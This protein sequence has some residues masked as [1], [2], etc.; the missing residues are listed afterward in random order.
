MPPKV[1]ITREAISSA[2]VELVRAQGADALNARSLT[3]SLHCSTQPIFFNFSSMGE[4]RREVENAAFA[5]YRRYTE[6]E[7]ASGH[8]PPYK[9]SG[10]AYI[11]FA[12]EER[13][14]FRLL[15]M[16]DRR[17]LDKTEDSEQYA[18]VADLVQ[19]GTG[20][21]SQQADLFHLEMWTFVHG[22]ATMLATG[23]LELDLE[24][25]SQMMTD[26]FQGLRAKHKA[27]ENPNES[28]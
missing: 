7:I 2:A 20:L 9:A 23:Y 15:Y 28:H 18:W 14:L 3:Q 12:K 27:K 25:I 10:M 19:S 13:E 22:I 24:L 1:K 26:V 4:L 8:Y 5:L 11:R 21:S 6:Q 16:R 17:E